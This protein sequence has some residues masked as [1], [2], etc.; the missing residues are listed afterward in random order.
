MKVWKSF[1]GRGKNGS[2]A[3]LTVTR[4]RLQTEALKRLGRELPISA[5][6]GM[7]HL[8][9]DPATFDRLRRLIRSLPRQRRH[10]FPD[11]DGLSAMIIG[12][13]VEATATADQSR[14]DVVRQRAA[15]RLDA[16]RRADAAM[17]RRIGTPYSS[18]RLCKELGISERNLELY[19]QEALGVSPK[20]WFQ[21]LALHR[22]RTELLHRKPSRSIVTEVALDC[23]FE[24]F[25]RFSQSYREV[26]GELPSATSRHR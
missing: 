4:E 18:A 10:H 9:V 22:A 6:G 5:Q 14:A 13:Y 1:T 17:R 16:V 19:F 2:W 21:H 11:S 7:G 23:G 15:Y 12:G 24:H 25:G 3:G 8:R 26:F 20:S